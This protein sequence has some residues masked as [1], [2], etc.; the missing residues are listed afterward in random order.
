MI[1]VAGDGQFYGWGQIGFTECLYADIHL[2]MG[3]Y[4]SSTERFFNEIA[5]GY[6]VQNITNTTV[7]ARFTGIQELVNLDFSP[8]TNLDIRGW[9]WGQPQCIDTETW[10]VQKNWVIANFTSS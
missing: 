7:N 9:Q 1:D 2:D 6:T 4:S 8:R 3:E 5:L 10:G